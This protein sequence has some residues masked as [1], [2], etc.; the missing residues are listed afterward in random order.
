MPS[1]CNI[2]VRKIL[3]IHDHHVFKLALDRMVKRLLNIRSPTHHLLALVL[4]LVTTPWIIPRNWSI[5]I[6]HHC[7]RWGVCCQIS[8][9]LVQLLIRIR[10]GH[11]T[12]L[13]FLVIAR[14]TEVTHNL[15]LLLEMLIL[16]GGRINT[17]DWLSWLEVGEAPATIQLSHGEWWGYSA[18]VLVSA[19][20][21][22]GGGFTAWDYLLGT[23][24]H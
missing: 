16:L 22:G 9:C 18:M 11:L 23:L 1:L 7:R 3:I 12:A 14:V 24:R 6:E 19:D 10:W 5:S 13:L 15:G 17:I 2:N 4:I 8:C 20:N 21:L